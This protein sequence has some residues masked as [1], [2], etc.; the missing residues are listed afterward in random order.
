[1]R[2]DRPP[3]IVDMSW[4][5]KAT[6]IDP[7]SGEV[8]WRQVSNAI[9]GMIASGELPSG[10]RLPNEQELAHIFEV[11]RTTVRRSLEDLRERGLVATAWGKG[12]IV[13]PPH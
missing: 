13:L 12:T 10:S 7:Y 9:A 4:E 8:I 6:Q 11:A 3:T 2:R 5:S 1:M